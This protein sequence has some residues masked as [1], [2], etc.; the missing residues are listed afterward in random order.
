M[1][2]VGAVAGCAGVSPAQVGQTVGTIAGSA[3]VPGIGAPVGAL[4]G[5]LTGMLVQ[6][7][8]DKVTE[9]RE[10]KELSG[11]LASRPDSPGSPEPSVQGTP[12]R[13]WIDE[14]VEQGRVI[15]GHF[16]TRA[17]P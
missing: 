8:V 15:A 6:G 7:E 3:V 1:I 9:K 11:Q 17:L 5:L 4:V 2:A 12:T 14:T 13:V 16:D 10:R